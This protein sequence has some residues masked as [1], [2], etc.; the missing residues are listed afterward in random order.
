MQE[1]WAEFTN[2]E[3]AW[4]LNV[5]AIVLLTMVVNYLIRKILI[6][7]RKQAAKPLPV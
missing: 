2:Y 7:A 4:I 5:F 6:R 3:D 1:F